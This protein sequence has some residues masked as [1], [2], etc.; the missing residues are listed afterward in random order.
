MDTLLTEPTEQ[1][2]LAFAHALDGYAYA[3]HRWPGQE[4]EARQPLTAFLKDGRFAPDVV[5][6]FAANFLLHRDFYSHGHLPSA[7][8]PNWYAMAFF[9]L[10]LYHLSVPEPWRHP[11]LYSGWAKLTT[12]ARESAAAEIREL[13]RQPDFLAKH[14]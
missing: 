8:T 2:I 3:A 12:E 6:N 10:H 7:N 5:D 4:R 1:I 13:L 11:Q 14:Y 9:Y